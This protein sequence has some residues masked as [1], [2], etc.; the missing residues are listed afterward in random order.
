MRPTAGPLQEFPAQ[1][2]KQTGKKV[3]AIQFSQAG[4]LRR[5]ILQGE[6]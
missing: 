3:I 2:G 6:E 5:K 1:E 4:E